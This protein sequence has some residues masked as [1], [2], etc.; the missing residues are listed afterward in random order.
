MPKEI[1]VD[2]RIQIKVVPDGEVH[3]RFTLTLDHL[4]EYARAFIAMSDGEMKE[5]EAFMAFRL[6]SVEAIDYLIQELLKAK[7]QI[8][9]QKGENDHARPD[10]Q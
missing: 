8:Q 9:K 5:G 3:I 2:P 4:A 7:R 1:R 6:R 10:P